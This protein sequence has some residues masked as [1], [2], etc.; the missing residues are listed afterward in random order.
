[1]YALSDKTVLALAKQ[2]RSILLPAEGEG[3]ENFRLSLD[4]RLPLPVV[5]HAIKAVMTRINY[6]LEGLSGQK[7]PAAVCVWRWE[8]LDAFKDWL[9]K[10][11][12]ET[13]EARTTERVQVSA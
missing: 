8:V 10:S 4:S 6:G 3:H 13:A 11:A 1:M 12:R 2:I 5:E 9:P 7:P